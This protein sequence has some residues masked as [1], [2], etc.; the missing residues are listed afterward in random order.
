[1][2]DYEAAAA[3]YRNGLNIDPNN[4]SLKSDL[5]SAESRIP[6]GSSA[7]DELT[8]AGAAGGGD[9][10]LAD[11]MRGMGGGGG[12]M[13]DMSSF[14]NNPQMVCTCLSSFSLALTTR[15]RWPRRSR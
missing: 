13:P 14:M 9:G 5:Q 12:G 6:A 11:M 7:D 4:A 8:S 3:A 10:G 15:C 1:M 2:G